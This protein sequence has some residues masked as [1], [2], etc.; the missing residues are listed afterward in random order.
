ML[1]TLCLCSEWTRSHDNASSDE[2]ALPFLHLISTLPLQTWKELGIRVHLHSADAD[3]TKV[4]RATPCFL[5]GC[6]NVAVF[7]LCLGCVVPSATIVDEMIL[8]L[9]V[10]I[11]IEA[12]KKVE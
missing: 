12:P 4:I 8:S 11:Q 6:E 7:I 1:T 3:W 5:R 2:G 10:C 9:C